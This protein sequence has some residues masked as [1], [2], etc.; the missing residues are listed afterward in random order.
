MIKK[1][2]FTTMLLAGIALV[3]AQEKQGHCSKCTDKAKCSHCAKST[4][5]LAKHVCTDECHKSGTCTYKH[6]E[7]GHVCTTACKK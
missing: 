4:K 7:E 6:G 5:K 2:L 3:N 1:F